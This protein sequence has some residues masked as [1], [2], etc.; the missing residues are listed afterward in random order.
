MV[1][2]YSGTVVHCTVL[3]TDNKLQGDC[4][5]FS[6]S[7]SLF[8]L[9]SL[10]STQLSGFFFF[11]NLVIFYPI[12]LTCFFCR[13]DR[14]NVT[15]RWWGS[16]RVFSP[17]THPDQRERNWPALGWIFL[18]NIWLG[19]YLQGEERRKLSD[20]NRTVRCLYLPC[21]SSSLTQ[22][23][24]LLTKLTIS[25][26]SGERERL[27]LSSGLSKLGDLR[28]LIFLILRG[29]RGR[30][31]ILHHQDLYCRSAEILS[32][33]LCGVRWFG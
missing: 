18:G 29:W 14:K 21:S 16:D 8:A 32:N 9:N 12:K 6:L 11:K 25:K 10:E 27:S 26:Y 22:L 15:V 3:V 2:W 7:I 13:W 33:I 1:Q 24:P 19:C 20:L 30:N 5:I 23:H 4:K 17:T 31:T 28:C